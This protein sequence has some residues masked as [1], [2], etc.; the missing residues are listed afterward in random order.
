MVKRTKS[1][2]EKNEK[3]QVFEFAMKYMKT[4][5]PQLYRVQSEILDS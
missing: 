3:E 1:K 2:K 5:D 4:K